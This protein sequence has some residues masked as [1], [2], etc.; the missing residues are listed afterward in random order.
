MGILYTDN[1][2]AGTVGSPI[3]GWSPGNGANFN[4]GTWLYTN[5]NPIHQS[6][7]IALASC[8]DGQGMLYTAAGA[9]ADMDVKFAFRINGALTSSSG[10]VALP[11]MYLRGQT[12]G[13]G[14]FVY[15]SLNVFAGGNIQIQCLTLYP[16][17]TVVGTSA[18]TVP[19]SLGRFP[20][21]QDIIWARGAIQGSSIY[22]KMWFDG[23]AEPGQWHLNCTDSAFTT[24]G[25]GGFRM[26]GTIAGNSGVIDDFTVQT[27]PA[28]YTAPIISVSGVT[29]N[30][31]ILTATPATGG[32][33]TYTYQWY[34]NTYVNFL[35]GSFNGTLLSGQ[36]SLTLNDV[37]LTSNTIYYYVCVATDIN[38]AVA[39]S[40]S[41]PVKTG[42]VAGTI[43]RNSTGVILK[44]NFSNLNNWNPI[45]A[46]WTANS[47]FPTYGLWGTQ[48]GFLQPGNLGQTDGGGIREPHWMWD[49]TNK[50]HR[51]WY[52]AGDGTSGSGG[53][54]RPQYAKSLD[55]GLSWIKYGQ[56]S[57][58]AFTN[59]PNKPYAAG[60]IAGWI[61]FSSGDNYWYFHT[62]AAG[63]V[64]GTPPVIDGLPYDNLIYR[65]T[66]LDGP[67]SFYQYS[68]QRGVGGS[69][70]DNENTTSSVWNS[71]SQ[72]FS[73]GSTN[74]S[75]TAPNSVIS[76]ASS[77]TGVWTP[78]AGVLFTSTANNNYLSTVGAAENVKYWFSPALN[79]AVILFNDL[80][81][82]NVRDN[83]I[84]IITAGT[85]NAM[86]ATGTSMKNVL[87]FPTPSDLI[88]GTSPSLP[89]NLSVITPLSDNQGN[90]LQ[91]S[92]G[93]VPVVWGG[94]SSRNIDDLSVHTW[95]KMAG[96]A[97]EPS[98]NCLRFL[99]NASVSDYIYSPVVNGDAVHEF[100]MEPETYAPVTILQYAYRASNSPGN[101]GYYNAYVLSVALGTGADNSTVE[102]YRSDATSNT[103]LGP[104]VVSFPTKHSPF[105]STPYLTYEA[106]FRI[107][108]IGSNH[109]VYLNDVPII[110]ASDSTYT[111]G[112]NVSFFGVLGS[113][114]ARLYQCRTADTVTINGLPA[115]AAVVMRA[116]GAGGSPGVL[117]VTAT[118]NGAGV[119]TLSHYHYPMGSF[120]VNGTNFAPSNY[121]Y[122]GD[123]YTYNSTGGISPGGISASVG[124]STATVTVGNA[125][126]GTAPYIY[127]WYRSTT[128]GFVPGIASLL[129]GANNQIL[130]DTGLTNGLTYYYSNVVTDS[131]GNTVS[132]SEINVVPG[133]TQRNH[134]N[135]YAAI[136][137]NPTR[138][139]GGAVLGANYNSLQNY[140][141]FDNNWGYPYL[142]V[143]ISYTENLPALAGPVVKAISS[144]TFATIAADKYIMAGF[145]NQIAGIPNRQFNSPGFSSNRGNQN[146]SNLW[147]NTTRER[148][149][150]GWYY[151]TGLP[152][153]AQ[154][155]R[156]KISNETNS[157]YFSPGR[158]TYL[159]GSQIPFSQSYKP[160]ND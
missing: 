117:A 77:P 148:T 83:R 114:H 11:G 96:G 120:D 60:D 86:S 28:Q 54:W 127:Q 41:F 107:V 21:N 102:L 149:T 104:G 115:N 81:N 134:T 133:V 9:V 20:S 51:L 159:F 74:G 61:T 15:P 56:L 89:N 6:R 19:Q 98:P 145:T 40:P 50:V 39:A 24:P 53:P 92:N 130:N 156:D 121:I 97:L 4:S 87:L 84:G 47:A 122:G 103:P 76:T 143:G 146:I 49:S 93:Y 36:T 85:L 160:R 132:S 111:S 137:G 95:Q 101:S 31:S 157:S 25:Y 106:K 94:G 52:G 13:S 35:Y 46:S 153:N 18:L 48:A 64:A 71:G 158:L 33:G 91:D 44:D 138:N 124:I 30:A 10:T 34:R 80:L 57:G 105:T 55:G 150:G 136:V 42:F 129:V 119:A 65:A 69:F 126:G 155:S 140:R 59:G 72:W 151:Q 45:G 3:L 14:Y 109:T 7:S 1:F 73:L 99:G 152:V 79:S 70:D 141:V 154:H 12:V 66:S 63:A 135:Y 116:P 17:V 131:L 123:I 29:S 58:W 110:Q 5:I 16:S 118:A 62:V 78:S 43:T 125:T 139:N 75:T 23:Q 142:G 82:S 27:F 88:G 128:Q 108:A 2:E 144:G 8:T 90:V 147:R 38:G 100:I 37:G 113:Y 67:W 112:A 68:P 26:S 22:Y 32:G